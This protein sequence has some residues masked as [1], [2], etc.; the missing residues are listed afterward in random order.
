MAESSELARTAGKSAAKSGGLAEAGARGVAV[1][2]A[3]VGDG[4]GAGNDEDAVTVAECGFQG[5]LHVADN[6]YG[7][8]QVRGGKDFGDDAANDFGD[9]GARGSSSADAGVG[10]L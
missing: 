9:F 2:V 10:N 3:A 5:D 7:R 4:A 1:Q 6:F 8:G